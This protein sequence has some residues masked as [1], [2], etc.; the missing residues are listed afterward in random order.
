MH[1]RSGSFGEEIYL[2][3]GGYQ[4]LT[5]T[6]QADH[7]VNTTTHRY[8]RMYGATNIQITTIRK[9]KKIVTFIKVLADSILLI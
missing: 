5:K 6:Y 9:G 1:S 4:A 8:Q 2:V 7:E 3:S